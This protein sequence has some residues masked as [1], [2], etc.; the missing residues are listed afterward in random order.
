M[1]KDT[2]TKG[3]AACAARRPNLSYNLPQLRGAV[4]GGFVEN[5]DLTLPDPPEF[6]RKRPVG[7]DGSGPTKGDNGMKPI[8][9]SLSSQCGP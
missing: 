4:D 2:F 6:A 8:E 9:F 7:V 3:R 5:R 1:R